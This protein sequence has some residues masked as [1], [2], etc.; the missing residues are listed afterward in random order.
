V[1]F[2]LQYCQAQPQPQDREEI[3]KPEKLQLQ[4]VL[5]GHKWAGHVNMEGMALWGMW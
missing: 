3:P 2:P 1:T 5:A 4:L